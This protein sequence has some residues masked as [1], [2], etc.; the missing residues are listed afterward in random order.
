MFLTNDVPSFVRLNETFP[1]TEKGASVAWLFSHIKNLVVASGISPD[2]LA[3]EQIDILADIIVGNYPSMKLTEFMLFES[4]F[5][6]GKYQE[7]YGEASY[8]M[9]IT[10]S[11]NKFR[12]DLNLIYAQIEREKQQ[13]VLQDR[14]PDVS[15][16]EYRKK[17]EHG[18]MLFQR[19]NDCQDALCASAA[20]ESMRRIF[21]SIGYEDYSEA[22]NR[23]LLQVSSET[24]SYL[25]STF[26]SHFRDVIMLYYPQVCLQY[27]IVSRHA[28]PSQE[29]GSKHRSHQN[30]QRERMVALDSA[31]RLLANT[32][33]WDKDTLDNACYA[34]KCRYGVLP[35][36]YVRKHGADI[37]CFPQNYQ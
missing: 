7:F 30:L 3:N 28:Q 8:I 34:F 16:E 11:L 19:W 36:E 26:F 35:D 31:R 12:Q 24:M 14:K 21:R 27:R 5:L 4:Y 29:E 37:A 9:A 17:F 13:S 22:E 32:D 25:E 20:D 15:C 1:D 2:N 6:G 18:R 33:G 10:K 23:L